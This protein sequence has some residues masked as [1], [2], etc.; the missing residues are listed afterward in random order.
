MPIKIGGMIVKNRI[1][2]APA[3]SF[4]A[5][6]DGDVSRELIE[7]E[8]AFARG[9]AGIVTVG[10]TPILDEITSRVGHILNIRTH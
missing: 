3:V 4:L 8:R 5:T 1:E 7:W 10:D 6:I 9:G 2:K